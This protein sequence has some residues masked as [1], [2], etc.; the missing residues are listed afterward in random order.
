MPADSLTVR[1]QLDES[2]SSVGMPTA[3]PILIKLLCSTKQTDSAEDHADGN[4]S[5]GDCSSRC[6]SNHNNNNSGNSRATN[7]SSAAGDAS[8]SSSL[9]V[10]KRLQNE[11]LRQDLAKQLDTRLHDIG[12]PISAEWSA[13]KQFVSSEIQ[14]NLGDKL[15]SDVESLMEHPH[16]RKMVRELQAERP[17]S[18]TQ[19]D[20]LDRMTASLLPK[21]RRNHRQ[22]LDRLNR[23]VSQ[24]LVQL[25]HN[26]QMVTVIDDEQLIN[27][28]FKLSSGSDEDTS[29]T[30]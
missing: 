14:A 18:A 28:L 8:R 12:G 19:T 13:I 10:Q 15:R 1:L 23:R 17:E 6:S 29:R 9:A 20:M 3:E 16:L 27:D 30:A 2:E 21:V 4:S 22:F 24:M 5:C 26:D 11:Q 25:M 7:R